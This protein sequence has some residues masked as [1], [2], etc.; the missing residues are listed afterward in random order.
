[1][2]KREKKITAEEFKQLLRDKQIRP[3]SLEDVYGTHHKRSLYKH[4]NT[5][6][7]FVEIR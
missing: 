1:M 2:N 7:W 6:A 4:P 5:G 3:A